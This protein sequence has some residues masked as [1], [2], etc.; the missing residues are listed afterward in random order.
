MRLHACVKQKEDTSVILLFFIENCITNDVIRQCVNTHEEVSSD[1]LRITV[2]YALLQFEFE[3]APD[4]LFHT[5][6][7]D[8]KVRMSLFYYSTNSQTEQK[9]RIDKYHAL[10]KMLERN[11]LRL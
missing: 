2:S 10:F 5:R 1:L 9:R 6:A 7:F 11:Y 3:F 4:F 8:F